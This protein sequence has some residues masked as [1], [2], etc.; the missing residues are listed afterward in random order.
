MTR[1]PAAAVPLVLALALAACAA[2]PPEAAGATRPGEAPLRGAGLVPDAGGLQPVGTALR[3]DFGREQQG[4]VA[5]VARLKDAA[6]AA[7]VATP[8]CAGA[9]TEIAWSDGLV[10]AFRR[11]TFIGWRDAAGRR[12][13][14]A[15]PAA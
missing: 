14:D 9:D 10:L 3:I 13:G 11:G 2:P 7:A 4:V 15:C 1:P 12:A 8:G 5:A 6:P